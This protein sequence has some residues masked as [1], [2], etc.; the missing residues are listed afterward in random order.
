MYFTPKIF[1]ILM[2]KCMRTCKR[3]RN[4]NQSSMLHQW[5]KMAKIWRKADYSCC[6]AHYLRELRNTQRDQQWEHITVNNTSQ[7]NRGS[8]HCVNLFRELAVSLYMKENKSALETLLNLV[9]C[10]CEHCCRPCHP[11]VGCRDQLQDLLGGQK[12]I[13]YLQVR[14]FMSQNRAHFS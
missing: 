11:A 2:L 5:R 8:S 3:N 12:P 10:L 6:H 1:S 9:L 13:R 4:F 7:L 14:V